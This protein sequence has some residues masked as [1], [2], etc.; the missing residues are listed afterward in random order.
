M[1]EP[2]RVMVEAAL[3]LALEKEN[4]IL[5]NELAVFKYLKGI[6]LPT[7]LIYDNTDE[8]EIIWKRLSVSGIPPTPSSEPLEA[9]PQNT[10]AEKS[11]SD[12]QAPRGIRVPVF[13]K[14]VSAAF[15]TLPPQHLL[16]PHNRSSQ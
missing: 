8:I 13:D 4:P 1:D 10:D 5:D 11:H 7:N 3:K 12:D 16:T 14:D 15:P 6:G 2:H 9:P